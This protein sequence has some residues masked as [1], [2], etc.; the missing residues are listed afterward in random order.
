MVASYVQLLAHRCQGKLD[1]DADEYIALAV[2]GAQRMQQ[3]I[4]DLFAYTRVGGQK[5]AFTAVDCEALLTR[6]L[7]DLQMAVADSGAVITHDPLPTIRGDATQLYQV[8]QNLIGNA[9]KFRGAA[10]PRVHIAA[11][12][13]G[14]GWEFSVRDNGIGIDPKHAERIFQVFQ[15]THTRTEYPGTGMGL[16]ICKKI[17]ERHGGRIWVESQPGAGSTFYFTISDNPE[18]GGTP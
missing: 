8:W 3:M 14:T 13:D 6:V 4:S 5:A 1:P 7:G 18:G 16:A 15:R 11:R 2:D 17:V 9:L 10:G 12:R